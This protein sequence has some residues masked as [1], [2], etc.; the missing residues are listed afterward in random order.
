VSNAAICIGGPLDGMT[1]N[2]PYVESATRD[3]TRYQIDLSGTS[4][5]LVYVHNSLTTTAAVH[6][7]FAAYAKKGKK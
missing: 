4:P 7:V 6:M 2:M 3:Y 1:T 5:L